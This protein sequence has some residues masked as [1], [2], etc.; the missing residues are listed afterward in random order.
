M[1]NEAQGH[2]GPNHIRDIRFDG[3][4]HNNRTVRVKRRSQRPQE[5]DAGLERSL[6]AHPEK[7]A[8]I[9]HNLIKPHM[10]LGG[11]TP[12]EAA[13]IQVKGENKWLTMIQIA[14]KFKE[15]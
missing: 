6:H 13:G 15:T 3:T 9:Y 10:G 11:R 1:S 8:Q 12:A 2:R 5:G 4:V 7:G 14:S